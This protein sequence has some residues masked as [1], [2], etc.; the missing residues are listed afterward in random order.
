MCKGAELEL[1]PPH[2][3]KISAVSFKP[4]C[5]KVFFSIQ[6]TLLVGLDRQ[7]INAGKT[8]QNNVCFLGMEH[9]EASG[10]DGRRLLALCEVVVIQK[11]GEETT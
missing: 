3:L 7:R 9:V 4:F 11:P 10:Q 6:D 5:F 8:N 1:F 2:P